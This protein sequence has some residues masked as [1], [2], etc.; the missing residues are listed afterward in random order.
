LHRYLLILCAL[1]LAASSVYAQQRPRVDSVE[2]SVVSVEG[3]TMVTLHGA[4]LAPR[5]QLTCPFA[6]LWVGPVR[7]TTFYSTD[8]YV[9]FT[10]PANLP[11]AH[12][13][14]T[15]KL[16][17][18][19]P[20]VVPQAIRYINPSAYETVLFP[21]AIGAAEGAQQTLWRTHARVFSE[22]DED[23]PFFG[24]ACHVTCLHPVEGVIHP[25][26]HD[27]P[28][29]RL[30]SV[31]FAWLWHVPKSAVNKLTFSMTVSEDTALRT[32][33]SY[34]TE[35]PVVT[36]SQLAHTLLLQ[37]LAPGP[38]YRARVRIYSTKP[39]LETKVRVS[40]G[41]DFP[42]HS[43]TFDPVFDVALHNEW[44]GQSCLLPEVPSYAEFDPAL[45]APPDWSGDIRLESPG[46]PIFALGTIT[47]NSTQAV[48]ILTPQKLN[49]CEVEW[50]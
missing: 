6:E 39:C 2:P 34:G 22:A 42:P 8:E 38:Q 18:L 9:T 10:A 43:P 37:R 47:S 30:Q 29:L 27:A 15:Y 17:L 14:I 3:G 25:Q 24:N 26:L 11:P 1:F 44:L 33:S 50:D 4:S 41:I 36:E 35:V 40:Y 20:L 48:T 46:T 28:V 23:I 45:H 21:L 31:P 12:Y 7:I 16:P 32:G 13:D 5:C 19:E 49:V